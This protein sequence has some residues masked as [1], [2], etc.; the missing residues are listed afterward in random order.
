MSDT[1]RTPYTTPASECAS[2]LNGVL[3]T[4]GAQ[5]QPFRCRQ[6]RIIQKPSMPNRPRQPALE[7]PRHLSLK[8]T[9]IDR[10]PALIKRSF[11]Q[12]PYSVERPSSAIWGRSAPRERFIAATVPLQ[13]ADVRY[14]RERRLGSHE[15][16]CRPVGALFT[17]PARGRL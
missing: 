3:V 5:N 15:V 13:T 12:S 7:K 1:L 14:H 16:S 6:Q 2:V 8:T 4:I 17:D 11:A 9:P 10:A